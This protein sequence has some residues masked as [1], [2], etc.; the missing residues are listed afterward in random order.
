MTDN[1]TTLHLSVV[2]DSLDELTDEQLDHLMEC[3]MREEFNRKE[4]AYKEY[5]ERFNYPIREN[6]A[7]S[8]FK[9]FDDSF[10]DI[11]GGQ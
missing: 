8:Y 3:V 10:S 1:Y 2:L 6:D 11:G 4:R 7:S 9:G 5:R